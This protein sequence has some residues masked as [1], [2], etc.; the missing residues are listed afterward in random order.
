ME[1]SGKQA[2]ARLKVDL[3]AIRKNYA[4]LSGI[5]SRAECAAVVKADAYG[6]GMKEVACSLADTVQTF[7][8]AHPEEGRQL[9][10]LLPEK[11][12]FI[13]HGLPLGQPEFMIRHNLIPVL[14]SLE[15]IRQWRSFCQR[16]GK[17]HSAALQFDTGMSRFGIS[18]KELHD[19][20][21]IN[22]R[23]VLLLSHL[24]CADCPEDTANIEQ[25]ERF[26]DMTAVFPGV[27][28]SLSASS[29]IFLGEKYH[30]EVVRPGIA[31][32]GLPLGEKSSQL[33]SAI[34]LE[35]QILQIRQLCSGDRIG[36]G[37]TYR[38]ERSMCVATVGIGYADGIFR[39]FSEFGA[40][41]KDEVRLPIR[42]R[43]SMDSLSVDITKVS[44]SLKEGDWLSVIRSKQDLMRL[45]DDVGTIGY[46]VLTS[47]GDRFDRFYHG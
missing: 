38:A 24:A 31:L 5:A 42:G 25:L 44:G 47:L 14:N 21:V 23:P 19:E 22:F 28:R 32:Y 2:S 4:Y 7:F 37:L 26:L 8:V 40:L 29:G 43:I 33:R 13:L 39:S 30:F 45:A 41:W 46:E 1:H 9:R 6:L 12:I 3:S 10:A 36:Y 15:Q 18:S 27:P 11:K 20:A 16:E 17:E 35:A 34:E